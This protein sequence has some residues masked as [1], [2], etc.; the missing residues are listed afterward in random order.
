MNRSRVSEIPRNDSTQ[1]ITTTQTERD[2]IALLYFV[3]GCGEFS[4]ALLVMGSLFISPYRVPDTFYRIILNELQRKARIVR[5]I[6]VR[7]Q[8]AE[9]IH[10]KGQTSAPNKCTFSLSRVSRTS[11]CYS[12]KIKIKTE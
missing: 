5:V 2:V 10:M 8:L 9:L 6:R 12:R 11:R 7:Q 4:R 1:L 3:S